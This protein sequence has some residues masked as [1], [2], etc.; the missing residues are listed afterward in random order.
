MEY[1]T[2]C[3]SMLMDERNIR[4]I[5]N[6]GISKNVGLH[7]AS[8]EF[9][10]D[11]LEYNFQIERN[12]GCQFLGSIPQHHPDDTE[13]I[14]GAQGFMLGCMLGYLKAIKVRARLY[15]TGAVQGPLP[16]Q[17]MT[18]TAVLEFFEACNALSKSVL[19]KY[20]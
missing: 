12:Y 6:D 16:N 1:F 9:Q 15:K 10:R 8:I 13:L 3:A 19:L 20:S 17:S 18:R 14:K 4:E 5:I 7:Q 11:V 2:V